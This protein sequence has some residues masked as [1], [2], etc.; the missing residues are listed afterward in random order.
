MAPAL[1]YSYS[2][3]MDSIVS[4]CEDTVYTLDTI[5][6]TEFLSLYVASECPAT[7]STATMSSLESLTPA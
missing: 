5:R 6:T 3:F 1:P 2:G 7:N 4:V